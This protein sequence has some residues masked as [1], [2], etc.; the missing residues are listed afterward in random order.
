MPR[1]TRPSWRENLEHCMICGANL[2]L[3]IP[4]NEP[5]PWM[6][7]ATCGWEIAV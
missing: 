1:L 2:Q 5:S 3:L 4:D 6:R 7:C